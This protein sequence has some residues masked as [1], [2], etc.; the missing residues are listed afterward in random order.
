MEICGN[1]GPKCKPLLVMRKMVSNGKHLHLGM[2]VRQNVNPPTCPFNYIKI[3]GQIYKRDTGNCHDD[4]MYDYEGTYCHDCGVLYGNVHHVEVD[5][6]SAVGAHLM[7]HITIKIYQMRRE[8]IIKILYGGWSNHP[9]F[10]VPN[11]IKM[12][13]GLIQVE[14]THLQIVLYR[15]GITKRTKEKKREVWDKPVST[16][17]VSHYNREW[18]DG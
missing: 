6:F 4:I 15:L 7:E 1:Y 13:T 17:V 2:C 18:M 8:N 10:Y 3:E 12:S 9:I 16:V 14:I 5:N 11:A